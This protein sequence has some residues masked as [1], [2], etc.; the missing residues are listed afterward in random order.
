[1]LVCDAVGYSFFV[2]WAYLVFAVAVGCLVAEPFP[3]VVVLY[4]DFA[5]E[6]G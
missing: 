5:V 2:A 1:M 3:A 4:A 6:S